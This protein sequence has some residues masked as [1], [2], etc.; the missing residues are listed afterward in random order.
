MN[1]RELAKTGFL[2]LCGTLLGK[3]VEHSVVPVCP[4]STEQVQIDWV[5]HY[6]SYPPGSTEEPNH[7]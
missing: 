7:D 6:N 2:G 4:A 1:R 3:K 5:I